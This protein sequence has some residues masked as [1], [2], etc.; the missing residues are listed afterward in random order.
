MVQVKM[1]NEEL[2]AKTLKELNVAGELIRARQ[3]EKQSLLDEFD[4][5]CKRFFFGK[6]SQRSLKSSVDKTNRELH[7]LDKEVRENMRK[8]HSAGNRAMR[9]ISA[10]APIVFRATMSGVVGGNL[11]KEKKNRRVKRKRR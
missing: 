6:I 5:E 3:E 4:S 10:Q 9:L 1:M 11:I 2:L 8:A 7:R